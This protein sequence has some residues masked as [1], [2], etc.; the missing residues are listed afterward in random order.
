MGLVLGPELRLDL[1]LELGLDL[2]LELRLDLG[3]ELRLELGPELRLEMGLE[4]RL[5]LG[6]GYCLASVQHLA[7]HLGKCR[8]HLG[9]SLPQR[10]SKK[11]RDP[12]TDQ[13]LPGSTG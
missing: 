11:C 8:R 13:F 1:G 12:H 2:G 9:S 3:L 4:L 5:E 7:S 10:D 6:L